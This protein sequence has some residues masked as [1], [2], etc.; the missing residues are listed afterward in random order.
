MQDWTSVDNTKEKALDL[1][2]AF[3]LIRMVPDY[4]MVEVAGIEPASEKATN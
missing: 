1:S 2:R 4:Q 3:G